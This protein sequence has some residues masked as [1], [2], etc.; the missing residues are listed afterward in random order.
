MTSELMS[1]ADDDGRVERDVGRDEEKHRNIFTFLLEG[2]LDC[3]EALKEGSAVSPR[4]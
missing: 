2:Q 4:D 1:K 3:N